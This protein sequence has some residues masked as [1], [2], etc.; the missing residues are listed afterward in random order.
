MPSLSAT[1]KDRTRLSLN[2]LGGFE[3]RLASGPAVT[4]PTRK[5]QALLA[6]LAVS[7]GR[8]HPRD[9]LAGLLWAERGDAQARD[10]LRHTLVELRRVFGEGSPGLITEGNGVGLDSAAIEVDVVRFE[11]LVKAATAEDLDKAAELYQG[12]FLQGF[13]LRE[14][15]F[16]EW[17]ATE[18]E[19]LRE[20]ALDGLRRLVEQQ[21]T[22]PT[23]EP[24]IR[25]AFQLL[26]LD[27]TQEVA[28]RALMRLYAQQGRRAAAFRQY[29][30]CVAVLQREMGA[31]PEVETR[32][33]YQEIVR[34]RDQVQG[35]PERTGP[36][37][38]SMTSPA[39]PAS[40]ARGPAGRSE[41]EASET[42]LIGRSTELAM[43]VNRFTEA[44]W[45]R[46]GVVAVVGEAGVGKSR[47]VAELARIASEQD[48]R[49]LVGRCYQSEQIYPSARGWT[50]SAPDTWCPRTRRCRRSSRY[51]G[52]SWRGC[53]PRSPRPACLPRVT[54]PA[55]CSRAW[56]AW[57]ANCRHISRCC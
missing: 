16:E 7:P 18:R 6:Y 13:V 48:G 8:M 5:A 53:F 15:P 37:V 1:K 52:R 39:T 25:S 35:R 17:L 54:T 33:L 23:S 42:P 21:A 44:Q 57:L 43:L 26:A 10:S 28:H 12:D 32:Q 41:P 40:P 19:R 46:G 55:A 22:M 36:R 29:Q 20:L 27:A 11:S 45:G 24:A 3:V 49:V 34:R 47:L 38:D 30:T 9:K 56:R 4:L 51:G 2:L 14:P 31:E 50:R